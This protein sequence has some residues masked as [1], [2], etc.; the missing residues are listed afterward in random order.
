[1]ET[2]LVSRVIEKITLLLGKVV[3]FNVL[4]PITSKYNLP[5][6]IA[7]MLFTAVVLF[8]SLKFISITGFVQ[9][10]KLLFAKGGKDMVKG[11]D[12]ASPL[13]A[14]LAI[15]AGSTGLGGVV[16]VSSVVA[17]AGPGAA[18]WVLIAPII[19]T[20][21]RYAEVYLGHKYRERN[22]DGSFAGG[23]SYYIKKGLAELNLPLLGKA[24]AWLYVVLLILSAFAGASSY[25]SNQ[26]V[27]I[28]G[29]QFPSLVGKEVLVSF[30]LTSLVSLMIFRNITGI[31]RILSTIAPITIIA[32][33]GSVFL[34]IIVN[35]AKIGHAFSIILSAAF[36]FKNSSD[37]ILLGFLLG[38]SRVIL[39][40]EVGLGTAA[41]M[42]SSSSSKN[43]VKEGLMS[44]ASPVISTVFV[45][46]ATL[47]A[48]IL[49]GVYKTG[50]MGVTLISNAFAT[51]HPQLKLVLVFMVPLMG[52]GVMVAWSAY[53]V[54]SAVSLFRSKFAGYVFLA[55]YILFIF[56]GGVVGNFGTILRFTDVVNTAVAIPNMIAILIL[57]KSIRKGYLEY[58]SSN[59]NTSKK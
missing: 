11:G 12:T 53:G 40:T 19:I 2:N 10:I 7:I 35:Y 49:T 3:F 43:S 20:P 48:V 4:Q 51:V 34:V 39:A 38:T 22:E 28:I 54:T 24:L 56:A 31:V 1:M 44:M 59:K 36:D 29:L 58:K 46:F 41:V 52:L 45:G 27:N 50:D 13:K 47:F 55:F 23:P 17:I 21:L 16:G 14:L 8:F 30:A 9:S 18:F 6:A 15:I 5:F 26:I 25:Q 33:F 37:K 32:Y 57:L 42:H